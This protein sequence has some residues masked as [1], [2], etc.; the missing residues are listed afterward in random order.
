[1]TKPK[2]PRLMLAVFFIAAGILHFVFPASY[3]KIVPDWLPW[4]AGLVVVSGLFEIAGGVGVLFDST[5][6]LAGI[7]LIA[8]CLAVLPANVQ[9]L[10]DAYAAGASSAW[11]ALL[12]VRLPAQAL[13]I[14]W[15]WRATLRQQ[16]P[17]GPQHDI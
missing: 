1:M 5:R 17:S 4:H 10:Q 14:F 8:L 7:G 2:L 12:W 3:A 11:L 15:I 16:A 9:M 13:L 6:R